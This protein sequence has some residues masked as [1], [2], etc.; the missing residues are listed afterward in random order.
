M[1]LKY[2]FLVVLWIGSGLSCTAYGQENNSQSDEI[3]DPLESFNRTIFD[4]NLG[5]D[6]AV[7]EPAVQVYQT[8]FPPIARECLHN[9]LINLN[10]PLYFVNC[11]LQLDAEKAGT[12]LL[13]F[14]VNSTFGLL[15]L[16][17]VATEANL[18]VVEE[19]FGKTLKM[20]DVPSGPYL[21]LPILGPSS[22]RD[23]I[24]RAVDFFINPLNILAVY[25]EDP[26]IFW[27]RAGLDLFD[28]RSYHEATYS[29]LKKTSL[30]LYATMRSLYDQKRGDNIHDPLDA[31][32]PLMQ[33]EW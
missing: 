9:A 30:D 17:D 29:E 26:A 8:M 13:R 23:G 4:I 15:G 28:A 14:I 24:G 19:N 25:L 31:P 10:Q 6:D 11:V 27:V 20:L 32:K 7:A 5:L 21:V 1:R 33:D 2:V 18:P 3:E 22:F 12:V 16:F